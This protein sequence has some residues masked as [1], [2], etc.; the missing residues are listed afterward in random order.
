MMV[1][2][3]GKSRGP[4]LSAPSGFRSV[5]GVGVFSST[6]GVKGGESTPLWK[7]SPC[8]ASAS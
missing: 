1:R 4:P 6:S 8:P 5:I 2:F 7:K 3:G